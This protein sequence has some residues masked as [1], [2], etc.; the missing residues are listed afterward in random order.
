MTSRT[1]TPAVTMSKT[2]RRCSQSDGSVKQPAFQFYTGDW[3]KDTG[4]LTLAGRGALIDIMVAMWDSSTR[5]IITLTMVQFSRLLRIQVD[6]AMNVVIELTDKDN[7]TGSPR[8]DV[9]Q[10]TGAPWERFTL[11]CRRM[12]RDAQL[13]ETRRECGSKGKDFGKLGG[14]P[15]KTPKTANG[16]ANN[17]PSS[18]S[19]SSNTPL[20]P[21]RGA[22]RES[23]IEAKIEARLAGATA[24]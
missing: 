22:E 14:R 11:T 24:F 8:L 9:K 3:L 5:G 17:P 20:T 16:T 23:E 13:S 12:V 7:P 15:R 2:T 4:Y 21:R 18:S 19:S 10:L 1:T 6:Q